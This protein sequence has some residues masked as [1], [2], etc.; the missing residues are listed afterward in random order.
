MEEAAEIEAVRLDGP[1][2]YVRTDEGEYEAKAV[3]LATGRK[4]VPLTVAGDCEQVHYCSIC[5]GPAYK[6]KKVL[7]VGGGNSGFDEALALLS[8]GV[9]EVILVEVMDRFFAAQTAQDK[10]AAMDNVTLRHSTAVER[11]ICDDRLTAAVLKDQQ[12]GE[13][14]TVAV[15]AVFVFMGQLPNTE[16]FKGVVDL[17]R[18]GYILTNENMHVNIDGVFAA[19]DV[20]P[21]KYRQITTAMA[22]G[23][24]AALEAGLYIQNG[25]KPA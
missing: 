4:P 7:V 15:D 13:T 24:I 20:R 25:A 14:E 2:K 22:D 1:V 18:Q 5:D 23:T 9:R 19:G 17:D 12:N 16:L 6:G 21:K 11:L 10:L 8:M 3:I